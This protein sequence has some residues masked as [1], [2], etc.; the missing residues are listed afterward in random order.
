MCGDELP[1]FTVTTTNNGEV[2]SA[3]VL[4]SLSHPD[5]FTLE[6]VRQTEN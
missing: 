5:L 3:Q 4:A 2:T 1:Q 6:M